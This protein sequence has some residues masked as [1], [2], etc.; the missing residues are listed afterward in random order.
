M[1]NGKWTSAIAALLMLSLHA[2]T[3][4]AASKDGNDLLKQCQLSSNLAVIA[5]HIYVHAVI[6]VLAEN[7][8]H[9]YR[10]CVP[11]NTDIDQSVNLIVGWLSEHADE[12]QEPASDLVAH[13]LWE[14]YPC[15]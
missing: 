10:V 5:C 15:I 11:E 12:R 13:A 1:S 2:Q 8:V 7:P 14:T 6:D 3:V 4:G 9:G